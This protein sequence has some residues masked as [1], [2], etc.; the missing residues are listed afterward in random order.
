MGN[1]EIRTGTAGPEG[2]SQRRVA[3]PQRV[4]AV[5]SLGVVLAFIDATIVN[6]AFPDIRRSFPDA[7]IAGL[8]WV[9]NAYNIVF[10]AFLVAAGRIADVLGRKRL[11][12]AGVVLFTVASVLCAV[13]PSLGVLV[14]MRVLQAL[15]AAIVV[16]AS[17]ALVLDVFPG[18]RRAHGVAMWTASAAIA[19]GL[20]PA[21][22]GVLVE[23]ESW[24]LAF[25][26][27]LPLG[28]LTFVLASRTLVESRAPGRRQVPDLPGALLLALATGT[29]TLGIVKGGDWGWDSPEVLVS[30]A[31]AVFLG[32]VF[33]RRSAR[34]RSP[35]IDL[36][37][38]RVRAVSVANALSLAAAAG[39]FAYLLCNVL[40]LT[41]VWDYSVLEAGLALTPGPF[42][43]AAVARPAE[44]MAH[45]FGERL[46]LVI[47][48]AFWA[49]GVLY[50][51][52]RLGTEPAFVSEWLPGM[53]ILGIGAG[54][55]FPVAGSA[56]VAAVP[57]G[58][59]ATATGINS[60][61]RQLGAVLGVALLVAI[62]GTPDPA[63]LTDAFDRGWYFAAGCF[64]LAG[65]FSLALGRIEP[66]RD[67]TDRVE[68]PTIPVRAPAGTARPSAPR[69][70]APPP[71]ASTPSELLARVPLFAPLPAALRDAVAAGVARTRVEADD[72]LFREGDPGNSL[73]VVASG[74]MEV[75]IGGEPVRDIGP[76][77]VIGEL[78]LLARATRSASIR[79]K[80]DSELLEVTRDAFDELMHNAPE[81]R[82]AL[83]ESLGSQLQ[84]SRALAAPEPSASTIFTL[85]PL[86]EG[87]PLHEVARELTDTFSRYGSAVCVAEGEPE[88]ALLERLEHE[89][90]RVLLVAEHDDEWGRFCLRH[91]DRVLA[92]AAPGTP[93]QLD[94]RLQD[95]ELLFLA[96]DSGSMP[97]WLDALSPRAR[98]LLLPGHELADS[99]AAAGR[100]LA[101]QSVGVVLSGGGARAFAHIGVI[102]ELLA[103]GVAVDRIGGSSFGA[104]IGALFALGMD[105]DEVDA[106]V[107]EEWVRRKPLSDY[108]LPRHGLIRGMRVR[109]LLQRHLPGL[110]EETPRDF[111]CVSVDLL[112][113]RRSVHRRGTLWD[114]VGGSLNLP[115]I[116]PPLELD[117]SLHVDGALLDNLPVDVMADTG[118]GPVIAVDVMPGGS[119]NSRK[120]DRPRIPTLPETIFRGIMLGSVPAAR[121]ARERA[122]F[123]INPKPEGVG[124]L[125]FH[126]ID[127][128]RN[129]G[130]RAA[131]EA[132]ETAPAEIF[133]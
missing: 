55:C 92:L 88:L 114:H 128:M 24:R 105:A 108:T 17:L 43:A 59:F 60:I 6:V 32:T 66:A 5:A 109:A 84:Q 34:H 116:A 103:A 63:E 25:L 30:F 68:R 7:S 44:A 93:G 56:A 124:L 15:G 129:S 91:A 133:T 3:S 101:G 23:L 104:L 79:A 121:A 37:L 54:I 64:A 123:V 11:F 75:R 74:R 112:S 89:N 38:F 72:F 47:G 94:P 95:C 106:R 40:F 125:E 90:E 107:Y 19:A 53:V 42:V 46:A 126:L 62:V 113:G 102:E 67:E 36:A 78:A 71:A 16:P 81:F 22:G 61:A 120:R 49:A 52:G 45:R 31:L 82:D 76:G 118:E 10:A 12:Q 4:L 131:I 21:L 26:V 132:L 33:L 83:L 57:G 58:R 96:G 87:V 35:M 70:T 130:R 69:R 98:H 8:S 77:G 119:S 97:P 13:A 127:T 85:T 14:A 122:S 100:R 115:G 27:N 117:G 111:Y 48:T 110:I 9:L 51:A 28:V 18:E 41:S 20:G 39:Y 73:F 86:R 1:G 2:W 99:V 29:L 80:R 65:L 50:M